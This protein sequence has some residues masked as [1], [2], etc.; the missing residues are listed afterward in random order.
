ME[1]TQTDIRDEAI[2][3]VEAADG[4][5]L[6]VRLVG[7]VAVA[8][9]CPVY[10]ALPGLARTYQD[11]DLVAH[12]DESGALRRLM[13]Q[14][15]YTPDRRFNAV[16]GASRLVFSDEASRREVDVFLDIFKMCHRLDLGERLAVDPRTLS[17]ADL[18]LTKL[19]IVR[20]NPKDA[21]DTYALL[22]EHDVSDDESGINAA[23]MARLCAGDWG[24]Y[25]TVMDRLEN[26]EA[27]VPEVLAD[28]G[29]QALA[30]ERLARL[31]AALEDEPKTSR[32]RLRAR[33]G[34]R[35]R[36]YELPEEKSVE[37]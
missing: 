18:L 11:I 10:A 32:W 13:E 9:R 3:I 1:S 2:R 36:W 5:G 15:G 35:V 22:L 8:L 14:I 25:T 19:Q 23:Y 17:L 27:D 6:S 29:L 34:R 24:W 16:H 7:G 37:L 30:R 31:R 28:P 33:L 26:L 4:A 21:Q 20:M 12:L